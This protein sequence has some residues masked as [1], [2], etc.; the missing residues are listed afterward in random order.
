MRMTTTPLSRAAT[1]VATA[2]LA[3][4]GA[5][6][7]SPPAQA[8]LTE[9]NYGFQSTAYGTRLQAP[10][11]QI[12]LP[13]T[14]FSF[15]S[16]T[17]L[18]GRTDS[19]SLEEQLLGS[20]VTNAI[21]VTVNTIAT[22][23]RSFRDLKNNIAAASQGT[24]TIGKVAL[25]GIDGGPELTLDG[26]RTVST[27]WADKSGKMHAKN[28]ISALDIDLDLGDVVPETGTPLDQLVDVVTGTTDDVLDQ[29]VEVIK[30]SP[31][32]KI[33]IPG[34]GELSLTGFDRHGVTKTT[35][36]AS[37]FILRLD[38]F[39]LDGDP[40][41][42]EDNTTV[43]IGR[44]WARLTK[45]VRSGVMSGVGV[46][47]RVS[48][49]N[50]L[51]D[52][53]DLAWKQLPCE[54]T[55][56]KVLTRKLTTQNVGLQVPAVISQGSGSSYGVQGRDGKATSWTRGTVSSFKVNGTDLVLEG[57][58]GR[59]NVKQLA[60]G[61]VV[62]SYAGSRIGRI[63]VGGK[64]IATGVTPRTAGAVKLPSVPGVASVKLFARD[65]WKR[66]GSISAVKVVLADAV[67]P[68]SVSLGFS[69]AAIKRF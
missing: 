54:G 17:R 8:A 16:C 52:I 32:G 26:L 40:K 34:L 53:G 25:G 37:S 33:T 23:S 13:R 69:R 21:P 20:D 4:G 27:A 5:V 31:L 46:G 49:G 38:L 47:S 29:V 41:T 6:V 60:S 61:R 55:A 2:G 64:V 3:L 63:L 14:A 68:I 7:L 11:A 43:S 62:T 65:T 28:D 30:N 1:L 19:T 9:T 48:S 22:K 44:S 36:Y 15:V 39:G 10:L 24:T 56:G 67:S 18:A 35:A 12:G 45:G 66:G 42:L 58:V 57:I 51:G 59:T 50:V